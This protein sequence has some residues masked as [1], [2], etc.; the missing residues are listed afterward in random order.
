MPNVLHGAALNVHGVVS[1]LV[2]VIPLEETPDASK[3]QESGEPFYLHLPE[4]SSTRCRSRRVILGTLWI[5][6]LS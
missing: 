6:R 3:S 2:D 1:Y 4:L 5:G